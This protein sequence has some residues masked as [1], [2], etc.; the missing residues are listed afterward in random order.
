MDGLANAKVIT[1][2]LTRDRAASTTW[3]AEVLG[4][5]VVAADDGFASVLDLNGTLLRITQIDG[6][7]ASAHPA[8]GWEVPDIAA[9]IGTLVS[10]GVTMT[11]YEGFGQDALGV[12]TSPDGKAKVAWFNDPDGNVLSLT[13][14]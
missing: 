1:F 9:V 5:P 11:I 3:Y 2:I 13:Q 14:T 10:R 12:W 8:L 4:L 6:Y 7:E